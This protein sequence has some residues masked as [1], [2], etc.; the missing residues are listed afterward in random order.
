MCQLCR[1]GQLTCGR[2][3]LAALL[4]TSS[5][6][7]GAGQSA[8]C[9]ALADAILEAGEERAPN[10]FTTSG[11]SALTEFTICRTEG[12]PSPCSSVSDCDPASTT[13]ADG[14]SVAGNDDV[15]CVVSYTNSCDTS[16]TCT[17]TALPSCGQLCSG[18]SV[19]DSL[20]LPDPSTAPADSST[21][22]PYDV[23]ESD[24]ECA[25][26]A[27]R[28]VTDLAE[29]SSPGDSV[30]FATGGCSGADAGDVCAASGRRGRCAAVGDCLS[31]AV[32]TSDTCDAAP[33][34]DVCCYEMYRKVCD[35]DGCW[36]GRSVGVCQE[37]C[38]A[39]F[40]DA[41]DSGDTSVGAIV[42]GVLAA[43]AAVAVGVA[44]VV[45]CLCCRKKPQP[46]PERPP[47]RSPATRCSQHACHVD[48]TH[49]QRMHVV[50][51]VAAGA[52]GQAR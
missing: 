50:A 15:C 26:T 46:G 35:S 24:P 34:D 18:A 1:R 19:N 8:Q 37:L 52:G 30:Q 3:A 21:S 45:Y 6:V 40:S 29:L 44:V 51:N 39:D 48:H 38:A 20:P 9:T 11:C 31:E 12:V 7:P 4:A 14:C 17:Q 33:A 25:A 16:G 13:F 22:T 28:L 42:G 43:L 2:L 47:V 23:P 49:A 10:L 36:V 41:G 32:L 5:A 27:N